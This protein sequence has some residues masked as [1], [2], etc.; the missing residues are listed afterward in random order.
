MTEEKE[1]KRKRS[2]GEPEQ[3]G[4]AQNL[5]TG[6]LLRQTRLARGIEL[7]EISAVIHVRVSQLKAIEEDHIEALPGMTYALGFVK[8]YANYLKLDAADI[9]AKFRAEHGAASSRPQI[10][11][12]EPIS[13]SKMPDPLMLGIAGFCVVLL[14]AAW[15][16]FSGGKD[17][18]KTVADAIPP[19]PVV[20]GTPSV[21]VAA[22]PVPTATAAATP[23]AGASGNAPISTGPLTAPVTPVQRAGD[24][25]VSPPSA[26]ASTAPAATATASRLVLP[27]HKPAAPSEAPAT[28]TEDAPPPADTADAGNPANGAINWNAPPANDVINVS[29]GKGRVMLQSTDFTWVQVTDAS[30]HILI[31]KVLRPGERYF[32]PDVPG[33]SLITSNAGGLQILVDGTSIGSLGDPGQIVRGVRLDPDALKKPKRV[34]HYE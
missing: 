8:S 32:V 11:A 27:T 34:K 28:E 24:S 18:D 7:E 4:N 5:K 16:V 22:P 23:V 13:E 21:L 31:K 6:E 3:G 19:A 1:K 20:S 17:S 29:R 30:R 10:H 15:A 14:I 26:P 25:L 2:H 9:L 33:A 12:P